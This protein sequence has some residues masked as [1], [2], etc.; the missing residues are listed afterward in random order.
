LLVACA[1]PRSDCELNTSVRSTSAGAVS[2]YIDEE[3]QVVCYM[4]STT[5]HIDCMPL[6]ETTLTRG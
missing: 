4:T 6:S 1:P 5:G 3:A 2:R